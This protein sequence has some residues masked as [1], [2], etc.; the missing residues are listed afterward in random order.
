MRKEKKV[1]LQRVRP[2]AHQDK[3]A[4]KCQNVSPVT[5]R[6][7]PLPKRVRRGV[8][9]SRCHWTFQR[10]RSTHRLY[11]S[12]TLIVYDRAHS[13]VWTNGCFCR[14]FTFTC[15][16]CCHTSH[17]LSDTGRQGPKRGRWE[18]RGGR[19]VFR[20]CVAPVVGSQHF[21]IPDWI[22]PP[23]IDS[24][25][26][27]CRQSGHAGRFLNVVGVIGGVL[28]WMLFHWSWLASGILPVRP[29]AK[30][31]INFTVVHSYGPTDCLNAWIGCCTVMHCSFAQ[32]VL[33]F[34]RGAV[35][36]W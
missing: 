12:Q 4:T 2:N 19:L 25:Y 9:E 6:A 26:G 21:R 23:N 11:C 16:L 32:C 27:A 22:P 29:G 33:L 34:R 8:D 17:R 14:L 28:C 24:S 13:A 20:G 35:P 15:P 31:G 5:N 30:T 3:N 1:N 18:V 36:M 7:P 10:P